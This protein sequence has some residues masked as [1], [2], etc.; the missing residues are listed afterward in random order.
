M[1]VDDRDGALGVCVRDG[2][3]GVYVGR[4]GVYVGARSYERDGGVHWRDGVVGVYVGARSYGRDG[5]AGVYV[6]ARSYGRDGCAGVYVGARSYGRVGARYPG[7]VGEYAGA[8]Y[9][10]VVGARYPGC[11]G[12]YVPYEPAPVRG[13]DGP[14]GRA[15]SYGCELRRSRT[16]RRLRMM[17]AT[18]VGAIVERTGGRATVVVTRSGSAPC[19]S[20]AR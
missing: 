1:Y 6:G 9:P 8:R 20:D 19:T 14:V 10:G 5:C 18:R 2:A 4:D 13:C 11:A 15:R 12:V 17:S 7:V 3:L 16:A